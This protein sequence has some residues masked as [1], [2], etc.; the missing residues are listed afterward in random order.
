[1]SVLTWVYLGPAVLLCVLVLYFTDYS[2]IA[3][4]L[5]A[6]L[7]QQSHKLMYEVVCFVLHRKPLRCLCCSRLATQKIISCKSNKKNFHY[8]LQLFWR[9]SWSR[10]HSIPNYEAAY[11]IAAPNKVESS[12]GSFRRIFLWENFKL[13]IKSS[14]TPT[15]CIVMFY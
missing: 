4:I 11:L 9:Y 7:L 5:A 1:M 2:Q 14:R 3:G 6:L 13:V 10:F 12:A 15:P 8:I